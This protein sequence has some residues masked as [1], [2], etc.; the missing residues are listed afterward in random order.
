LFFFDV[1]LFEELTIMLT[2]RRSED[3]GHAQRGWLDAYHSFSFNTYYDPKFM[4]F[5]PLRVINEDRFGATHGFGMHPHENMEIVTYVRSGLLAHEDSTGAKGVLRPGDVQRM[6]AGRGVTH[7]EFNASETETLHLFQIWIEPKAEHLGATPR[8][9]EVHF[10]DAEK[11][12]QWRLI[13]SESG[14][15]GSLPIYQDV[16][17]YAT[18]LPAG[19]GQT[20]ALTSGRSAYL[21]VV[22]GE[23]SVNNV[24]LKTGD[25][26]MVEN[27][28]MLLCESTETTELLLF[29]LG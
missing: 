16:D 23:L 1:D 12:N 14:R 22:A 10:S 18:I 27:E 9:G 21:H 6:S 15:D 25:A 5:G 7:S 8:Y 29:D 19:Q 20:H 17:L 24:A 4:N 28:A 11:T 3:R 26:L 13:A 2:I